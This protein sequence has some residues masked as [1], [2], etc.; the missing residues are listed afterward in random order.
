MHSTKAGHHSFIY[1]YMY[2]YIYIYVYIYICIYIYI[3]IIIYIYN[4]YLGLRVQP[5]AVRPDAPTA[6]ITVGSL[7]GMLGDSYPAITAGI[8]VGSL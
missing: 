8:T 2:I 1:I 3:Y 7:C 6:G 4:F 5:I